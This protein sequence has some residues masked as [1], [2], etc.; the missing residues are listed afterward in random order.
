MVGIAIDELKFAA[1]GIEIGFALDIAGG[2]SDDRSGLQMIREV[3]R[4]GIARKVFAGDTLP[5]KENIFR[6][7][8]A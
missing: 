8:C 2:I 6:F 5:T 4:D 7:Q 1:P 3:I